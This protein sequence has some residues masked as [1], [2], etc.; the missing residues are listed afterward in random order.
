M[1]SILYM[2]WLLLWV[3]LPL[4]AQPA[5]NPDTVKAG[6]FDNGKMWTFD[7]PPTQHFAS[8]YGFKPDAKWFDEVRMSALRFASYCSASFVSADGLVMTNHHCARESGTAVQ[9]PGEDLNNQGF[10][11]ATIQEERKVPD[12]YVDQLVRIED[13]TKAVEQALV[14]AKTEAEQAQLKE[15]ALEDIKTA[16]A[17]KKEWQK[18]ELQTISFYNGGRYA[19]YGFKRY[20]DVRLV[21]MPELQL[22]FFGGDPDNF[23]Y[24]RYALDCSFFRVYDESGK[25]LKTPYYF[26]FSQNGASEGEPVFVIG[27]PGTTER[28]N[29]VAELEFSRDVELPYLLSMLGSRSRVMQ[30]YQAKSPNDSL[31]NEIFSLENTIKSQ[32]G[33]LKGL[34]DP[35]LMARR[36]AY[37]KDFRTKIASNPTLKENEKLWDDIASLH[38]GLHKPTIERQLF[39]PT[40]L[41]RSQLVF[42]AQMLLF[43]GFISRQDPKAA[44]GIKRGIK[45]IAASML[46]LQENLLAAYLTEL[47]QYLGADDPLVKALTEGKSPQQAAATLVSQSRMKDA[48]WVADMTGKSIDELLQTGDPLIRLALQAVQRYQEATQVLDEPQKKIDQKKARIGQLL[49]Q[50]YGNAVPPDATF[51]LRINDGVVT[52]YQYNGTK[53]PAKTTFAGLYDRYYSFDGKFPWSLPER[54]KNPPA[55]LLKAPMNFVST[56]DIIGGNSGSPIIN[57]NKDVV[58]L[59][60]DSNIEALPGKFIYL[61]EGGNR[62]LSV[63]SSGMLASLRYIY[64][65]DRL[66][67]EL[68]AGKQ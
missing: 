28:N 16:Y 56:N 22:G 59:A 18:L 17:K 42:N 10:Y 21:F 58:G 9:K 30:E 48:K 23:T 47:G 43:Y 38:Q 19:L 13:I 7:S 3:A 20:Q 61:T 25:P 33:V 14:K 60:F 53:A 50:I 2:R 41:G 31:L 57:K 46:P 27:N 15:K 37:E 29:T 26:K 49:Y 40:P 6:K 66:L 24:P 44:E 32:A 8:T 52:G 63:H 5:F 54:W 1:K 51:S 64:K 34:Q 35:Y 45:P 55:E 68:E 65:A 67:K 11:A 39:R 12:L 4:V 62:T 36:K